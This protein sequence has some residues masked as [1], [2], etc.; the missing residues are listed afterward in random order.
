MG[1]LA[2]APLGIR[3]DDY[4]LPL[5]VHILGALC[6]VGSLVL[7]STY[8]FAARRDGTLEMVQMGFRALLVWALPSYLV[9]R[10]GAEWIVSKEHLADSDD[11]WIGIGYMTA[12]L[13]LLF[14]IAST[15][16]AWMAVKKA[17]E[18][19]GS[20]GTTVAA[21]LVGI[22]IVAYVIAIWAMSTKPI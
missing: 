6:L 10:V 17:R 4:H 21:T 20:K 8:L 1:L 14:I 18:G 19:Q 22:L 12:D 16:A 3:P 15:I 11:A 13:G 7:A 5:F 9:M 2:T